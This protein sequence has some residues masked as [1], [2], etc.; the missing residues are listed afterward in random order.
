MTPRQPVQIVEPQAN[1]YIPAVQGGAELAP[2]ASHIILANQRVCCI[3]LV[4]WLAHPKSCEPQAAV[5]VLTIRD[6]SKVG[7]F[8]EAVAMPLIWLRITVR[9]FRSLAETVRSAGDRLSANDL[10][11]HILHGRAVRRRIGDRYDSHTHS[12]ENAGLMI[13]SFDALIQP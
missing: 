9:R 6:V 10:Y 7:S 12:L 5:M 3:A 4:M 1:V 11:E 8:S 2:G 13:K